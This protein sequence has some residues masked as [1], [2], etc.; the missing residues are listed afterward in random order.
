MHTDILQPHREL[1]IDSKNNVFMRHWRG[2]LSLGVS[3]WLNGFILPTAFLMMCLIASSY[4]ALL[5]NYLLSSF[6]IVVNWLVVM[7]ISVWSSTGIWR[8]ANNTI[9]F[10]KVHGI[11]SIWAYL[12]RP[13][14]AISSITF[15]ILFVSVALPQLKDSFVILSGDNWGKNQ[16][17]LLN[18]NTEI[19][20][21]GDLEFGISDEVEAL[22]KQHPDV[23]LI[24]LNSPGGRIGEGYRLYDLIRYNN[25]T[26]Y[27]STE[28]SSACTYAFMGGK[29]RIIDA[30]AKLGFHQPKSA[31]L[32]N[33]YLGFDF[34]EDIAF[35]VD[36][37]VSE[38]F[39]KKA[40][41]TKPGDMWYPDRNALLDAGIITTDIDDN[42]VAFSGFYLEQLPNIVDETLNH[43]IFDELRIT[44]PKQY[45]MLK[46]DLTT[47]LKDGA[48]VVDVFQTYGKYYLSQYKKHIA[49][50]P[51]GL[52]L[53]YI[54]FR[55]GQLNRG[56]KDGMCIL[57]NNVYTD[58][59]QYKDEFGIAKQILNDKRS[60]I[61]VPALHEIKVDFI[62]I[63]VALQPDYGDNLSLLL[64]DEN[65]VT[66]RAA[67]CKIK[68]AFYREGLMLPVKRALALF[69]HLYYVKRG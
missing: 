17:R 33:D 52:L 29:T 32:N 49:F 69:R 41:S 24:H 35:F 7:A 6:C 68:A 50:V 64:E 36:N 3:F 56:A 28:C 14:L 34:V 65:N 53:E 4:A 66:D 57:S 22:L 30:Q 58:Y 45:A 63:L 1:G 31:G 43:P 60:D 2:E 8:S 10:N 12:I 26:T 21:L 51:D 47:N 54:Q 42:Y 55:S 5:Q 48:P 16:I 15:S 38:S 23:T 20:V 25:L 18:N 9:A 39:I 61:A 11:V 13:W 59:D 27:T 44:Q 19:E 46:Q 62:R 67:F 40:Y 37:G